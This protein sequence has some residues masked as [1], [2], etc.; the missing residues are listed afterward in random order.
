MTDFTSVIYKTVVTI[1][2]CDHVINCCDY[3]ECITTLM[4]EGE[5]TN[6]HQDI[7]DHVLSHWES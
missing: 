1:D 4:E 2:G 3:S 6:E 7:I 5:C